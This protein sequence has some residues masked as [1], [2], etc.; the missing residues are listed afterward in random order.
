MCLWK[1]Y[2][3]NDLVSFSVHHIRSHMMPLYSVIED[4][5]F[6][7]LVKVLS[8]WKI[9]I[10]F[11][12]INVCY[13]RL[14]TLRPYK[15]LFLLKFSP[16]SFNI[17]STLRKSF[18]FSSIYLCVYSCIYLYQCGLMKK[19]TFFILSL[20]WAPHWRVDAKESLHSHEGFKILFPNQVL[21]INFEVCSSS[22]LL[23]SW[24][25]NPFFESGNQDRAETH[26]LLPFHSDFLL[27]PSVCTLS[28]LSVSSKFSSQCLSLRLA[29]ILRCWK[30]LLSQHRQENPMV[31]S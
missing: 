19:S 14:N 11:F 26:P 13:V 15:C 7:H 6:N 29:D 12:V 17:H 21:L 27:F 18:S 31:S 1:E 30:S 9:P 25:G 24:H 16:S 3:I 8:H 23:M 5:S 22:L 4:V 20:L 28:S 2:H 10:V